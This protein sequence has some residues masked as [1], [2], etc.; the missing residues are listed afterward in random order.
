[1]AV[2]EKKIF[3]DGST[4]GRRGIV[5]LGQ[6]NHTLFIT[7]NRGII[8]V[9]SMN[10]RRWKFLAVRANRRGMTELSTRLA[11]YRRGLTTRHRGIGRPLTR[12]GVILGGL[13]TT[14]V[15][16]EDE[17]LLVGWFGC[18]GRRRSDRRGFTAPGAGGGMLLPTIEKGKALVGRLGIVVSPITELILEIST[19]VT[20]A[21]AIATTE[22]EST[23]VFITNLHDSH[24]T[25]SRSRLGSVLD[26]TFSSEKL[27]SGG[28]ESGNNTDRT[29]PTI[30]FNGFDVGNELLV[31]G[32]VVHSI[33]LV[34]HVEALVGCHR[35]H[36][37]LCFRVV[38]AAEA[39][40]ETEKL[41]W[42]LTL[43]DGGKSVRGLQLV[44]EAGAALVVN[45]HVGLVK[46]VVVIIL[47]LGGSSKGIF[48]N[49]D[50]QV[51]DR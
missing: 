41:D 7:R 43:A 35:S 17:S 11:A 13:G 40:D 30:S 51:I 4:G 44:L 24:I 37:A 20:E 6:D 47:A 14:G 32:I 21:L 12:R 36:H 25:F 5:K 46:P 39:L 49:V 16:S 38:R 33:A 45:D 50:L 10:L 26:F 48:P 23:Q 28:D 2:Q 31:V 27:E 19:K 34:M 1:M 29:H 15:L 42:I 8:S 3:V 22:H 9:H 18:G